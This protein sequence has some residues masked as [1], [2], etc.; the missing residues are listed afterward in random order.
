MHRFTTL[1]F[2]SIA[3]A[4]FLM[5]GVAAYAQDGPPPDGPPP[6]EEPMPQQRSPQEAAARE[7]KQLSKK[8]K[9]TN[10][11][12]SQ[13][14]PILEDQQARISALFQ[15]QPGGPSSEDTMSKIKEIREVAS[16]RIRALL[17]DE[18]KAE[19]DKIAQKMEQRAQPPPD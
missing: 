16:G 6:G 9:L 2:K 5:L 17:T 8:L 18:Q 19:Y 10:D 13:I 7:L 15:G 11:Q 3:L 12:K 1:L 4:I 14:R